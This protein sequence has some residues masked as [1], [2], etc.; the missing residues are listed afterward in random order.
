MS[1]H[2][3]ARVCAMAMLHTAVSAQGCS[4]P[5]TASCVDDY[6]YSGP[7]GWG[8]NEWHLRRC[9]NAE[10]I[11]GYSADETSELLSRCPIACNM[12]DSPCTNNRDFTDIYGY[13]CG[14]WAH[15]NCSQAQKNY[16]YSAI[17][18]RVLLR[19]C[20]RACYSCGDLS[21]EACSFPFTYGRRTYETCIKKDGYR[22]CL[23]KSNQW[24]VC[25]PQGTP[26]VF[27]FIYGSVKYTG[28]SVANIGEH[29]QFAWCAT[30][31]D[32]NGY[33][34]QGHWTTCPHCN[35]SRLLASD[36]CGV[37]TVVQGNGM[38]DGD[39]GGQNNNNNDM[40]GQNNNN[41]MGGNN[42]N[43]DMGGNNNDMGND[44]MNRARVRRLT[45]PALLRQRHRRSVDCNAATQ[46]SSSDDH[47]SIPRFDQAGDSGSKK[48]TFVDYLN[49][50]SGFMALFVISILV[51]TAMVGTLGL[52]HYRSRM[53]AFPNGYSEL[54][55]ELNRH[56]L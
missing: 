20:Q 21:D 10:S 5:A 24:K 19:N 6:Q 53:I 34:V 1:S 13:Q 46:F 22:Q 17:Q 12:C 36:T 40:G 11:A 27:P 25:T 48:M 44:G 50:N 49:A 23:T 54:T 26:C 41:D 52:R 38:G 8:C 55:E 35:V 51:V 29:H 2:L 43:N 14:V 33:A 56:E 37:G 42:N 47:S 15:Y 4:G 16:D 45:G 3:V 7:N 28:C 18:E 39:M 31:V 32:N 9:S 30:K